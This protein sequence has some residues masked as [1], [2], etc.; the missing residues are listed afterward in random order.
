[1]QTEIVH[2]QR[3]GSIPWLVV[4]GERTEAFC[5]LGKEAAKDI[6]RTLTDNSEMIEK[7]QSNA[8]STHAKNRLQKVREQ[9]RI[10]YP[11][12]WKELE[13]MAE[14]ADV[15]LDEL[16][17]F[18]LHG[19]IKRLSEE[20]CTDVSFMADE[21]R[22]IFAHNEDG[23]REFLDHS[24]LLTLILEG[25]PFVTGW[26][27]PGFLPSNTFGVNEYGLVWGIDH[28]PVV[29]PF[30]A[31][32]RCFVARGIQRCRTL[33]QVT[34]YFSNHPSAG[35]FAY[36]V[37]QID[38]DHPAVAQVEAA[39]GKHSVVTL[40]ASPSKL[41]WHTNHLRIL[42]SQLDRP[43]KNSLVRGEIASKWTAPPA[44]QPID[45]CIENLARAPIPRGVHEEGR[46]DD[47]SASVTLATFIVDLMEGT[48]IL[49]PFHGEAVAIPALD[50]ARG[51]SENQ[52]QYTINEKGTIAA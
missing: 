2:R 11:E 40:E 45:W 35:G 5:L 3:L 6:R 14:G 13:A 26:W 33:T 46:R 30:E 12:Y 28:I 15:S 39:A 43:T 52:H 4:K 31:P 47:P 16:L 36:N 20:A 48:A 21:S 27:L 37:G 18:N 50:L 23:E 38:S 1:M 17:L 9:S 49:V 10:H 7:Y 24:G 44:Q 32:G 51:I 34:S 25:E 22:A 8:A 19:D 41:L 29:V 42:S